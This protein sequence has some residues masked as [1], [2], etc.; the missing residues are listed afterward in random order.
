MVTFK[1][2]VQEADRPSRT[3]KVDVEALTKWA[4]SNASSYLKGTNFFYRGGSGRG[5]R[6]MIGNSVSESPRKSA[7]TN[8][9]YTLWMDNFEEFAGWP[10]RSQSF[11]AIDNWDIAETFG[12]PSLLIIADDA[13]VGLTGEEDIWQI[14]IG[15]KISIE[16]WNGSM[17]AILRHFDIGGNTT[18]A[19]LKKALQETTLDDV[20]SMKPKMFS[21][22]MNILN[23]FHDTPKA[24]TLYDLWVAYFN[25]SLFE[26]TS[27]AKVSSKYGDHVGEIWIEGQVGFVSSVMSDLSSDERAALA[28]WADDY[29][30]FQKVLVKNWNR[31]D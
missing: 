22:E 9:N 11:I 5:A 8:N 30:N 1:Q 12:N 23:L 10:K 14:R 29:P 24:T 26:R 13:K 2:F 15:K 16:Q 28:Q 17:E 6:I 27:G 3:Q 31:D 4:E 18:F 25:P 21:T 7:N 19:G 20:K